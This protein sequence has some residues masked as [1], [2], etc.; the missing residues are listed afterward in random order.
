MKEKGR[1]SLLEILSCEGLLSEEQI[2][3]I[4]SKETL[5]RSKI[6][7]SKTHGLRHTLVDQSSISL[8]DIIESLKITSPNVDGKVITP[9]IIMMTVAKHINLPFLRID[10]LKLDYEI[11]T[12]IIS[13]P[14]A[15]RHQVVPIALTDNT[16]TIATADPFDMEAVDWIQRVT[17]HKVDVVVTTKSDIVK[18]ITEFFGFKSAITSANKEM[19][20]IS[21]LG[22]LEQ[23]KTEIDNRTRATDQHC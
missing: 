19:N 16:L 18:I 21:D 10:P 1:E 8:I 17:G 5:Q 11:V 2:Q 12:Q 23:Y 22:N 14:Y 20:V 7:K 4:K 6:L 9:D 15:I 3:S 13:R